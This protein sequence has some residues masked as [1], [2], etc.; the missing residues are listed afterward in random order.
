MK[1][2][3]VEVE[4][5]TK[6]KFPWKP[7][8]GPVECNECG[9]SEARWELNLDKH[10]LLGLLKADTGE[11]AS[12]QRMRQWRG[13]ERWKNGDG[14]KKDWKGRH[15]NDVLLDA[16]RLMESDSD[17]KQEYGTA[18]DRC[19]ISWLPRWRFVRDSA[20]KSVPGGET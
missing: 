15:C 7:R 18:G 4:V 6:R 2:T 17:R 1:L 14:P 16:G 3:T 10:D 5:T 9:R 13:G 11:T 19:C 20:I 8:S 12:G